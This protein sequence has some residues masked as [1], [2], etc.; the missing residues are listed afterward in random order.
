MLLSLLALKDEYPGVVIVDSSYHRFANAGQKRRIAVVFGA[1]NPQY[2]RVI[3]IINLTLHWVAFLIDKP[4]HVCY[5][6]DPLQSEGNYTII[7]KS[8]RRVMGK[9]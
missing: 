8:A 9:S 1:S 7:E 4:T 2:T 3:N 6:S 5:M